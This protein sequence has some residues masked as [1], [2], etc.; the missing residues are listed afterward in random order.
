MAEERIYTIIVQRERVEVSKEIYYAYH[1][2]CE[3]EHYQ[4]HVIR[5]IEMSLERF[6]QERV[7]AKFHVVRSVPG[8]EEKILC[9]RFSFTSPMPPL[10]R[11]WPKTSGW[12]CF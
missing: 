12:R 8:V 4:N 1:K 5:Q 3:A 10:A 2:A 11:Q 9:R 7:N 6:W